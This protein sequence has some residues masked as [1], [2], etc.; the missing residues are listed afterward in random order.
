MT[1]TRRAT[2][3]PTTRR[4]EPERRILHHAVAELR[5]AFALRGYAEPFPFFHCPNEGALPG[6]TKEQRERQAQLRKLDGVSSGV[7]DLVI[8]A[9]TS[10]PIMHLHGA[11][12]E[13]KAPGGSP[14]PEQRAWLE[15]WSRA[16]FVCRVFAGHRETASGLV[17]LGY[18]SPEQRYRWLMWAERVDPRAL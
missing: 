14:T 17:E 7:P 15:H 3:R 18:I 9:P 6:A 1:R 2:A 4:D 16:G 12:I 13:L 5:A 10:Y 11:A 8:V